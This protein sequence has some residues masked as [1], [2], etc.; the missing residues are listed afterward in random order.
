MSSFNKQVMKERSYDCGIAICNNMGP[1]ITDGWMGGPDGALFVMRTAF[2]VNK[3]VGID[4]I[5]F[6]M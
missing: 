6:Q 1:Q 2:S 3:R 5:N 4:K